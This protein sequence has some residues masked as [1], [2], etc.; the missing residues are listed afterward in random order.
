MESILVLNRQRRV[1][2]VSALVA[3]AAKLALPRC[4]ELSDDGRFAL[5]A[6][7]EV[8]VAFVSDAAMAKI[9]VDFMGIEGP[10]DVITFEHGDVVASAETARDY[11]RQYGH[12]IEHELAL[13]TI[14]GLLHLNGFDDL[15]AAPAARMRRN[16]LQWMMRSRSRWNAGR[17]L[18]SAPG[19]GGPGCRRSWSPPA[20]GFALPL[21]ELFA[22]GG[23][24]VEGSRRGGRGPAIIAGFRPESSSRARSGPTPNRSRRG[25]GRGRQTSCG[26]RDRR[27]PRTAA[28][29]RTPARARAS[30]PCS[31]SSDRCRDRR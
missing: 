16:A 31:A 22:N 14:H 6:L 19:A 28:P 29:T 11:A 18:S 8:V 24:E 7:P 13:Y 9:H 30:D 21:L 3:E 4:L 1:P 2:L 15:T 23:H 25:S 12:P 10:T 27:R 5:K 17:M 26:H 20:R